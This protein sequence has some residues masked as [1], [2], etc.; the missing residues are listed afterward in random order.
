MS[1]RIMQA[2][3]GRMAQAPSPS[4]RLLDRG[5]LDKVP[6]MV[7]PP[8]VG[9]PETAKIW[10]DYALPR[11]NV[12]RHLGVPSYEAWDLIQEMPDVQDVKRK[13]YEGGT[14]PP[15]FEDLLRR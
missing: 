2:L 8:Q 15:G 6:P 1:A 12:L 4:E 9:T 5:Y 7:S 3:M 10:Q 14:L 13:A 11:V